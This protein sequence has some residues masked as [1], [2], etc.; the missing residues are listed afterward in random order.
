M[1][2]S[3]SLHRS[4][5]SFLYTPSLPT[6][7]PLIP[8]TIT[9]KRLL[10]IAVIVVITFTTAISF[11]P[12]DVPFSTRSFLPSRFFND[13]LEFLAPKFT[14][15][16]SKVHSADPRQRPSQDCEDYAQLVGD[17]GVPA[18]TG[19][20]FPPTIASNMPAMLS[21]PPS[22]R[23]HVDHKTDAH[24]RKDTE[25][26]RTYPSHS[27]RHPSRAIGNYTSLQNRLHVTSRSSTLFGG[28]PASR[29]WPY[30]ADDKVRLGFCYLDEI[31]RNEFYP[32]FVVAVRIWLTALGGTSSEQ[33]GHAVIFGDLHDDEGN[34]IYCSVEQD[35]E[36]FWNPDVPYETISIMKLEGSDEET[37]GGGGATTGYRMTDP[38]TPW[39]NQ[40]KLGP[41]VAEPEVVHEVRKLCVHISNADRR[42]SHIF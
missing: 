17:F 5:S 37:Y 1:P 13:S 4:L 15:I 30:D 21:M 31:T 8:K 6:L 11:L 10:K 3:A 16:F 34:P 36:Q 20:T 28:G 41:G 9:I 25:L 35:G 40:L 26:P 38:P 22:T 33:S 24:V 7:S 23:K 32:V 12:Y 39:T 27:P 29:P 2:E 19:R 18:Y 14:E 42:R